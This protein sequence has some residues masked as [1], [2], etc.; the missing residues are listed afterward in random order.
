LS[1]N[2][3]T[4]PPVLIHLVAP[5]GTHLLDVEVPH[6]GKELNAIGV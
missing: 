3:L 2:H 1:F 6:A 4:G 5:L